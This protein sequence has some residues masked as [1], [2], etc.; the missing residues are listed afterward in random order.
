MKIQRID[1]INNS[2]R[3]LTIL[4][5]NSKRFNKK[6]TNRLTILFSY[7]RIGLQSKRGTN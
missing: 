1:N 2:V 7:D 4:Y 3:T 5:R 6:S